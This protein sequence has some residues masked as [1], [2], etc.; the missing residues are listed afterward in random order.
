MDSK[1]TP[2]TYFGACTFIVNLILIQSLYPKALNSH[3]VVWL[4]PGALVG[5]IIGGWLFGLIWNWIKKRQT[6]N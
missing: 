3:S 1:Y 2:A 5:G 6:K 4:L